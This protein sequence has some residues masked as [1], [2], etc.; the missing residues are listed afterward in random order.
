MTYKVG[1]NAYTT[2]INGVINAY[3]HWTTI[4]ATSVKEARMVAYD[5]LRQQMAIKMGNNTREPF[6]VLNG[7]PWNKIEFNI[8][9]LEVVEL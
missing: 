2:E 4:Q 8:M 7:I 9:D 6:V 1:M 5:N 3:P